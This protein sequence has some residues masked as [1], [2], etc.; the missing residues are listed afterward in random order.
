MKKILASFGPAIIIAAVVL[1]PGSILTSSKVGA[2]LG[3][4]GVPVIIV[5]TILMIGMVA[6]AARLGAVY[7]GSPCDELARRL[8][9]PVAVLIGLILFVVV[10]LFQSSN[11]IALVGGV[12]PMFTDTVLSLPARCAILVAVNLLVIVSLY[13]LRNLYGAVEW[14][15]KFLIGM[16]IAAFLFNFLAVMLQPR[17][18]EPVPAS[19]QIDWFALLGMIGTSFS[20]A[21]AFYQA[22]LIKEKGWG[23]DKV[24][25]GVLDSVVG[26]SVLGGITAIIMLTSW[27]V[28]YGRPDAIELASVADVARQLEPLFGPAAKIIFCT[29]ILAGALSSFMVNALIGGTI[30][31]DSLNKGSSLHDRWPIHLTVVALLIGMG[32]AIA[33]LA[34]EGSTVTLI[35]IAQALTVLGLPA[36]ALAL[37]YLGTRPELIGPRQVPR[38]ILTIAMIGLIVACILVGI[39]ANTVYQKLM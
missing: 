38:W 35:T 22:Y 31:S 6:L 27:R 4:L 8:G 21:G 28:F 11:N 23:L 10:A 7:E 18:Y 36:L 9:R 16:M 5:A 32:V 29:G 17:G 33:S 39:T 37:V 26:I 3:L 12:E 25:A 13:A 19:E 20:V 14:L 34:N 15:M 1:G 2:S 30:L 24:R